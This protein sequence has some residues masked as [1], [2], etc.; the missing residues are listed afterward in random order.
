M[1]GKVRKF[2]QPFQVHQT[3]VE[4][5]RTAFVDTIPFA[6]HTSR[7]VTHS[8]RFFSLLFAAMLGWGSLGGRELLDL[9]FSW[10]GVFL[11]IHGFS[12]LTFP[13]GRLSYLA[14]SQ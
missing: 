7:L 9:V 12:T 13:S 10:D 11:E 4:P 2:P 14:G 8:F 5:L 3:L 1:F 6:Y